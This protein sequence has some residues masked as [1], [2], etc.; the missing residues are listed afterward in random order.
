MVD[1]VEILKGQRNFSVEEQLDAGLN[2]VKF[3][4]CIRSA[5]R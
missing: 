5:L 4:D 1:P 3:S 2:G